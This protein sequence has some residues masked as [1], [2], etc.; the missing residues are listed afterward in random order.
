MLSCPGCFA[1]LLS[2]LSSPTGGFGFFGIVFE[3]FEH[4]LRN[5]LYGHIPF[6]VQLVGAVDFSHGAF[7]DEFDDYPFLVENITGFEN[8]SGL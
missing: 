3:R 8:S 7:T 1:F 2:V 5:N 4:F 6:Q